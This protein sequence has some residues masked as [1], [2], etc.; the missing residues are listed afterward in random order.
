M[1]K[2]DYAYTSERFYLTALPKEVEQILLSTP[3]K[4][5]A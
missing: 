4:L 2:E 1:I 3:E 5:A